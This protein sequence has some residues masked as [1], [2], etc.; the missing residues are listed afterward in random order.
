MNNYKNII[1]DTFDCDIWHT[2]KRSEK[3]ILIYGMGNG[4]DKII[5][6]FSHYDI[7]NCDVFASDGFVRGH[8]YKGKTVISYSEAVKKY[9]NDF[10]IVVSFGSKLPDVIELI[11]SLEKNHR[12]YSPDVPVCK[13]ELFT[14]EFFIKHE[15]ELYEARN[16]LFDEKSKEIF[17]NIVRFKLTGKLCYLRST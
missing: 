13:G 16:L 9:G 17:D 11:Y 5:S 8:Q 12:V 15:N 2:L 1:F 6:A 14:E 4:A 7:N 3:P 10:D